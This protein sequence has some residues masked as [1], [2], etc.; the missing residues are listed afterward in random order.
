MRNSARYGFDVFF[1]PDPCASTP[2]D[3]LEDNDDCA[4]A[5]PLSDG[6][7]PGLFVS[8]TDK[9]MYAICV[10][11]GA[12]LTCDVLHVASGNVWRCSGT[13]LGRELRFRAGLHE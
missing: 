8:K 13:C 2:D 3:Y 6:M 12:T 10:P 5:L 11:D 4:T 1:T 7:Y 9:D